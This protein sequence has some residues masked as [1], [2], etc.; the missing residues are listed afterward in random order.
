MS[1]QHWHWH[2]HNHFEMLVDSKQ[3]YPAMLSAIRSAR[4]Y[5]FLE[6]YLIS[7][8][9]VLKQFID[10]L[11]HAAH[12][13]VEIFLLLDDYGAKGMSATDREKLTDMGIR[14]AFY[15]PFSWKQ[16]HRSMRRNHRKLLLVDN[17]LAFVGGACISDD[18]RFD[19]DRQKSWH[20]IVVR[21]QGEVV[22]DWY[23]V[24]TSTWQQV[25]GTRISAEPVSTPHDSQQP[26]RI[27]IAGGPG[28]NQIMRHAIAQIKKSKHLVWIATPYFVT[29]H[30]LRRVLKSA[31]RRGVDVR[32]LLP[33][34]LSDHTWVTHAARNFY[35]R[36][37]KNKVRIYEY[38][39][40]FIHAKLIICDNWVSVGSSNLD[41]WNQFWNLDA[42]QEIRDATFA[43]QVKE[44]FNVDFEKSHPIQ[45]E[46]WY[47]R[48]Y[49]QRIREWW[50][51]HQV[52]LIQWVSFFVARINKKAD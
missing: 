38:R 12:N 48:S 8:G 1:A 10:A 30:K 7:S 21:I 25:T 31:A 42:N 6:Q 28:K 40:R 27:A 18:Y 19:S 15:N 3:F 47:Q 24:F 16:L 20:D 36:L 44:L 51:G 14:L 26:G 33:G 34:E 13:G 22:R 46:V 11:L 5:I 29:T 4:N 43:E 32:L 17:H 23:D 9:V 50:F 37:L 41:R 49:R 52:R 2:H 45:P 35:T 39:P